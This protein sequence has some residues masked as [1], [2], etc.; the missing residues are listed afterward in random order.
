[1]RVIAV[2]VDLKVNVHV[3]QTRQHGHPFGRNQFGVFRNRQ[4]SDLADG[5]NAL[6]FDDYDAVAKRP[7]AVAVN[8]RPSGQSFDFT[9]LRDGP[10]RPGLWILESAG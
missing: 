4:G 2:A 1:M 8:Q 3:P 7:P 6:A 9:R 10:G 5:L